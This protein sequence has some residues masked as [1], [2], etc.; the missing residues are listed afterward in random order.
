MCVYCLKIAL[1][2][3]SGWLVTWTGNLPNYFTHCSVPLTQ[4]LLIT[5]I[6]SETGFYHLGDGSKYEF[7]GEKKIV[8][9]S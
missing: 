2:L 7:M 1:I 8:I 4:V 6:S 5:I 9:R 3:W